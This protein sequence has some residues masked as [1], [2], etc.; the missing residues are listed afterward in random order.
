MKRNRQIT[1]GII[2]LCLLFNCIGCAK[3]TDEAVNNQEQDAINL[4]S[5]DGSDD[6]TPTDTADEEAVENDTESEPVDVQEDEDTDRT[7]SDEENAAAPDEAEGSEDPLDEVQEN[8]EVP[9]ENDTAVEEAEITGY[10]Y[11]EM[12]ATMYASTAI[13]VRSLPSVDG[14]KIGGL[15]AGQGVAVTG[16]CNETSWYRIDYN[17]QSGYVSNQYIIAELP[18]AAVS[19]PAPETGT[20]TAQ[21]VEQPAVQPV[22]YPGL[23]SINNLANRTS[24]KK[25]CTDAEFQAAYDVAAQIVTPLIGLSREEQLTGIAVVLRQ[26]VDVGLV[27]YSTEA[28]HYNDPYGYLVLGV[29][30][31]AGCT[32]TTGLCLNMLGISYEHVNE[33]Q[34]LHQWCRVNIDGTYWICDAYGLYVGPEPG[35]YVHP[36]I[37]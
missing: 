2:I 32:R 34:W 8:L 7:D 17:G 11:T 6:S 37:Y 21:A 30:S 10:T 1:L 26:L 15:S 35:P 23:V 16:Q 14:E 29:S 27:E 20:D 22:E 28:P 9:A 13:N 3:D 24:L 36:Y 4:E 19:T 5:T 18:V 25:N 33:N 31:C 12:E